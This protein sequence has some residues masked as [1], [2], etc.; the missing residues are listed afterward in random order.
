[1]S[2]PGYVYRV[3]LPNGVV[4]CETSDPDEARAAL[5]APGGGKGAKLE[6]C[7]STVVWSSWERWDGK[8]E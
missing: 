2:K 6:R 7:Y 8:S 3:L 1:M 4:W 5:H